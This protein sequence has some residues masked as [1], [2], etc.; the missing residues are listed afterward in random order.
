MKLS[1]AGNIRTH[2]KQRGLTQEQLA[3]VLGVTTGA[4]HKWE[5]GQSVPEL[6]LIVE[7]ADFFDVSVDALLGYAMKDGRSGAVVER[8]NACCLKRDPE[9]LREAEKALKKYPNSLDVVRG[10]AETYL[11]F[12]SE[13][14]SAPLIR[15][16]IEL[17]QQ[18]LPLLSQNTDP[19]F[20]EYTVYG[21]IGSAYILLGEAEK[22]LALLKEHNIGGLFSNVIGINLALMLGR[23]EEAA[24]Y[25]S[26][27]LV[28]SV[29]SLIDAVGGLAVLYCSRGEV[30]TAQEIVLWGRELLRGL[31]KEGGPDYQDKLQTELLALQAY[32]QSRAGMRGEALRS[33][34]E[35]AAL[36]RRFDASPV[37]SADAFRFAFV[38]ESAVISDSLGRTAAES[39]EE[40][41]RCLNEPALHTAW[42]EVVDHG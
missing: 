18:E 29:C 15:R 7:L 16:G 28:S 22:G 10:C 36:A 13:S 25:L 34:R 14:H 33:L 5:T 19:T 41:L 31:K 11:L 20:S 23:L 21:Q 32:T 39:V 40:L 30:D 24:P 37:Y 27:T 17:L 9:A 4:V 3:E 12:G 2:R 26:A 1:L 42:K 6:P 35:A 38:P 8:L